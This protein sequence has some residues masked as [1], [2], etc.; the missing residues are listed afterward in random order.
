MTSWVIGAAASYALPKLGKWAGITVGTQ[1]LNNI[2][3]LRSTLVE[4]PL[5]MTLDD[6]DIEATISIIQKSC[7]TYQEGPED[8]LLARKYVIDSL[9]SVKFHLETIN[10]KRQKYE[11]SYKKYYRTLNLEKDTKQL[12]HVVL[13]LNQRYTKMMNLKFTLLGNGSLGF[14]HHRV[15]VMDKLH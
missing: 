1:I 12:K 2:S 6:L 7:E 4:D 9:Q 8:F 10:L 14:V 5:I 11:N 13:I 15:K 3:I